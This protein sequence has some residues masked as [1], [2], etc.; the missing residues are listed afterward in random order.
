MS[1]NLNFT[2]FFDIED[3][4][5]PTTYGIAHP[6]D[7]NT[8]PVQINCAD[9]VAQFCMFN[10]GNCFVDERNRLVPDVSLISQFTQEYPDCAGYIN[11]PS[12]ETESQNSKNMKREY[13]KIS[14]PDFLGGANM[15][16]AIMIFLALAV[17]LVVTQGKILSGTAKAVKKA[18]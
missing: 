1:K 17:L 2:E 15:R 6:D 16:Q 7:M 12:A 5:T 18:V 11:N 8:A 10:Q 4:T 3:S 14:S 9:V 13:F